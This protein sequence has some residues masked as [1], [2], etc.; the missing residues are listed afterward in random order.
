MSALP[1]PNIYVYVIYVTA[2]VD[3]RNGFY[4][5]YHTDTDNKESTQSRFINYIFTF[6]LQSA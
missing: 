4:R 3:A 5:C 2:V 1:T 6:L